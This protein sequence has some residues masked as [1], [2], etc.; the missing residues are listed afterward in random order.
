M[1][2]RDYKDLV[3]SVL[4]FL[5]FIL[6]VLG[7]NLIWDWHRYSQMDAELELWKRD[8]VEERHAEARS[9]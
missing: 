8:L 3:E 5:G 4:V 1:N 9:L 6:I 2:R 7:I